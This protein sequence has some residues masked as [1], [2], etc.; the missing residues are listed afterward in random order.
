MPR[1]SKT[2]KIVG[3]IPNSTLGVWVSGTYYTVG[4]TPQRVPRADALHLIEAH[5][6]AI[7]LAD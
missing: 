7:V 2:L 4:T 6:K 1:V 5:Y 3:T